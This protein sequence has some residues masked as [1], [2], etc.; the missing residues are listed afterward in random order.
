MPFWATFA[1]QK[2]FN[3]VMKIIFATLINFQLNRKRDDQRVNCNGFGK[4]AG[5]KHWH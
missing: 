5:Q 1:L 3:R 2:L 4:G